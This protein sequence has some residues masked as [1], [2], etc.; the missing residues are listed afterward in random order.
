[1]PEVPSS[2]PVLKQPLGFLLRAFLFLVI[3][4]PLNLRWGEA[5]WPLVSITGDILPDLFCAAAIQLSLCRFGR[6][7]KA[8]IVLVAICVFAIFI[9]AHSLARI[10][11]HAITMKANDT[12]L[13]L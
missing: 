7:G 1:M 4:V 13:G 6:A 12:W 3:S 10:L 8:R 2:E 11:A 5:P 9:I